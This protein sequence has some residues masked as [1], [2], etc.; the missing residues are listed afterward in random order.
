MFIKMARLQ[1]E[2]HD[3]VAIVVF[4]KR[5]TNPAKAGVGFNESCG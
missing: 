3:I 4:G 2:R 5:P 1:D